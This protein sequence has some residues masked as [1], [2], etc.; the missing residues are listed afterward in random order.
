MGV[1]AVVLAELAAVR[2]W[3]PRLGPCSADIPSMPDLTECVVVVKQ[4][5]TTTVARI[6][7]KRR[8]EILP[9]LLVQNGN[10]SCVYRMVCVA[11][12]IVK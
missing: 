10:L 12:R 3:S 9:I 1:A 5:Q 6:R 11:G 4:R 8:L 7:P 2:L